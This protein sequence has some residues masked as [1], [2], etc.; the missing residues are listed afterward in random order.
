MIG[1]S[2]L[3]SNLFAQGTKIDCSDAENMMDHI[4]HIATWKDLYDSFKQYQGCDDGAYAEG[5]SDF[6]VRTLA[7]KWLTLSDLHLL[8][9]KDNNFRSFVIQ[10]ID[11]TTDY[12]D[13]KVIV[14]NATTICPTDFKS[15]CSDVLRAAEAALKEGESIK[16]HK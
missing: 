12:D 7:S 4:D 16:E 13:L 3:S 10:H 14:K 15:L 9:S 6:V 8:T 5:Y 11:A 2:L 1:L